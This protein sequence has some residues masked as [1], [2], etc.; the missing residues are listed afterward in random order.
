[1]QGTARSGEPRLE[2]LVAVREVPG[3]ETRVANAEGEG[4]PGRVRVPRTPLRRGKRERLGALDGVRA[5]PQS[6]VADDTPVGLLGLAE[7]RRIP[8]YIHNGGVIR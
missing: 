2:G 6:R 5:R 7:T 4:G 3:V 8:K 1:M